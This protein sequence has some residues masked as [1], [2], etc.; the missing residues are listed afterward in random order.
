MQRFLI[1]AALAFSLPVFAKPADLHTPVPM[2]P[3][4][5]G[6]WLYDGTLAAPTP[7]PV[8][9]TPARMSEAWE[10]FQS[11]NP[12]RWDTNW[13]RQT[14]L[15]ISGGS[16]PAPGAIADAD[17]AAEAGLEIVARHVDLLAPGASASDFVLVANVLNEAGNYR[18]LGFEQRY[19]GLPVEGGHFS[20]RIKNDRIFALSSQA[21]PFVDLQIDPET[22]AAADAEAAALGWI[23]STRGGRPFATDVEGPM[24]L[25]YARPEGQL[26]FERVLK[27]SVM[28]GANLE[29]WSVYVDAMDGHP[30][31]REQL[32]K[33]IN[34][35]V[36]ASTPDGN[37][38]NGRVTQPVPNLTLEGQSVDS[39][40]S[41]TIQL[42]DQGRFTTTET[43][44][45]TISNPDQ[46]GL[47]LRNVLGE[48]VEGGMSGPNLRVG[49]LQ[50]DQ[51]TDISG[52]LSDGEVLSVN[53]AGEQFDDATINT[54][55]ST[56]Q[57][58]E[59]L[60]EVV[61]GLGWLTN[62]QLF[63]ISN[64]NSA[65]NAV[66]TGGVIF[67][68]RAGSGCENTGLL[69]DV[70]FHE[71]G[72]V[73]H[74]RSLIQGVG[75]FVTDHSEGLSDYLAASVTNDS[76]IGEGIRRD[77]R[78]IR[79][80]D[81]NQ[82]NV[83]SVV[84][85][86]QVQHTRGLAYAGAMWDLRTA[87]RVK[88]GAQA[89]TD[90]AD[91]LWYETTRRANG[92]PSTFQETIAADDDDGDLS[93]GTPNFCEIFDAFDE[94]ELVFTNQFDAG[95]G[96][97]TVNGL[98]VEVPFL[99]SSIRCSAP[100]VS[101]T[102]GW[103][104]E[105]GSSGTVQMLV[106][107]NGMSGQLPASIA[108]GQLVE[109]FITT[110]QA[111]GTRAQLPS[112]PAAPRFQLFRGELE[113][114]YCND[115]ETNPFADGFSSELRSGQNRPGAND[116]QW[117]EPQ[118]RS[119][120][121]S[122]SFSGTGAIGNDLGLPFAGGGNGNGAYQPGLVNLMSAPPVTVE[123][124]D[125]Y[126]VRYRRWLTVEDGQFD[127]ATIAVN[128]RS[129]WQNASGANHIDEQWVEHFVDIT[130]LVEEDGAVEVDFIL[131][132][133][134]GANFGGWNVDDLCITGYDVPACG[135]G[136]VDPGESCDDGNLIDGDGCESDCTDTRIALCGNG[137]IEGDEV[138]DDGNLVDG[139]GCESDCTET[140]APV[141]GNG[142]L[143][144]GEACDDGNLSD[145]DGCESDCTETLVPEP[146]C[147]DGNIDPG[148]ACDDGNLFDGDGCESTCVE[149]PVEE[150]CP[151]GS[152]PPCEDETPTG[153]SLGGN[154]AEA[155]G[156]CSS[157]GP[158]GGLMSALLLLGA[159]TALRRRRS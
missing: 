50:N 47:D 101:A 66:V 56:L 36:N 70:V 143:E 139:D 8:N 15:F 133:D 150:T 144:D 4:L 34:G 79:E 73:V 124:R 107:P 55:V 159:F 152:A 76:L 3:Q 5:F 20:V 51:P 118:G 112:N 146:T 42:D 122:S 135:D 158:N 82:P 54:Y 95:T 38:L 27:V 23:E 113:E 24:I 30:V 154:L 142:I 140:P 48:I 91:L 87:L 43:G 92:I 62:Q 21:L 147:G 99:D 156:G 84:G 17:A 96:P 65:C 153:P 74:S 157:T 98:S 110:D 45:V 39:G 52:T 88:L 148:E 103:T 26:E 117:G 33:F 60:L 63:A 108:V 141:C 137:V 58:R 80:T 41:F 86:S 11:G 22:L 14:P 31:A 151:D 10:R 12:G 9:G 97:V 106:G 2:D 105:D 94:H 19:R 114:F 120:D 116:W 127:L 77:N 100:T 123:P 78:A 104:A 89:G 72:H 61:P 71:F 131:N 25:P 75:A 102:L 13:V 93:N 1:L 111:D 81:P 85:G 49:D 136:R 149:T 44:D 64:V 68:F 46:P 145:G 128:R 18:T 134:F 69:D 138:C 16:I 90:T 115:F 132:S 32:S 59:R 67:M 53:F 109:F 125:R 119:G 28:G 7:D 129:A 155:E 37:P 121:P 6:L 40:A 57:V 35:A 29:S 126:F 130:D 83:W